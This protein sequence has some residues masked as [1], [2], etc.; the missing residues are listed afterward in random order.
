[1]KHNEGTEQCTELALPTKFVG[2]DHRSFPFLSLQ[3][4]AQLPWFVMP[5]QIALKTEQS[6]TQP[7]MSE[8][9][10]TEP[11]HRHLSDARPILQIHSD[12]TH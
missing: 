11:E 10:A 5:F 3:A 6:S 2:P 12:D 8:M 9:T 7:S 1:L 4:R